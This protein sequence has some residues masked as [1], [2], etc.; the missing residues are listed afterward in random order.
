MIHLDVEEEIDK[1]YGAGPATARVLAEVAKERRRQ[2]AKFPGQSVPS[3]SNPHAF[4]ALMVQH[5]DACEQA[6][7]DGTLTWRHI[8]LE[9]VYEALAA[10]TDE[11]FEEEMTQVAAVATFAVEDSRHRRGVE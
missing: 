6:A 4:E 11:D 2:N 3:G 1:R 10:T 8:L 9:E 5:R 7:K